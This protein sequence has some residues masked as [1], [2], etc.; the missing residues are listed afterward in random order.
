MQ[1]EETTLA[2]SDPGHVTYGSLVHPLSILRREPPRLTTREIEILGQA[3]DG[4]DRQQV[5]DSL[6]L[7]KRTVDFHLT[8]V[9]RKLRARSLIH[10]VNIARKAGILAEPD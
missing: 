4:Y 9:F 5:A 1:E 2:T 6:F 10:A 8:N 7:S 3:A